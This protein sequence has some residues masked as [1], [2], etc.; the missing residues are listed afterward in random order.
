MTRS[1]G[2][3]A[4]LPP[5]CSLNI[6]PYRE[7]DEHYTIL[8]DHERLSGRK[9]DLQSNCAWDRIVFRWLQSLTLHWGLWHPPHEDSDRP[10]SKTKPQSSLEQSYTIQYRFMDL[11]KFDS[12]ARGNG[13][14]DI[15]RTAI[16]LFSARPG[17][18]EQRWIIIGK[19]TTLRADNQRHGCV[20]RG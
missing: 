17:R 6:V 20:K 12:S 19:V 13:Y 10:N 8:Y 2:T 4:R 7:C 3:A 14:I 16:I 1:T 18:F 9:L 11:F 15:E 5:E